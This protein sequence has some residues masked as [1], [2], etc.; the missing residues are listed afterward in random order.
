MTIVGAKVAAIGRSVAVAAAFAERSL[1]SEWI[2]R[3]GVIV[4]DEF[5]PS[6]KGRPFLTNG[7]EV[8][9]VIAETVQRWSPTP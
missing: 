8:G 1:R 3:A 4:N 5:G 7:V 9:G 2:L 6:G